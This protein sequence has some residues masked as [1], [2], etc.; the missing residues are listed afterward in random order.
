MPIYGSCVRARTQQDL[1]N[2]IVHPEIAIQVAQSK[3]QNS[4]TGPEKLKEDGIQAHVESTQN[5]RKKERR[6]KSSPPVMNCPG[7]SRRWIMRIE[8]SAKSRHSCPVQV[9]I[10]FK[11][12]LG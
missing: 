11:D 9:L 5:P 3:V 12:P 7:D 8:N 6:E 4:G 2:S 1:N 10:Y